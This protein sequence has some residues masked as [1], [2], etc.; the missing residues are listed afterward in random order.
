LLFLTGIGALT[1]A[2][3]LPISYCSFRFIEAPLTQFGRKLAAR[4]PTLSIP[5]VRG[6]HSEAH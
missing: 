1:W 2:I 5:G 6:V 4:V 3:V